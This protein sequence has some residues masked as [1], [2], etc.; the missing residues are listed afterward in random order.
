MICKRHTP[1]FYKG[2]AA[3]RE[4]R[5]TSRELVEQTLQ[6]IAMYEPEL[7]ATMAASR[8]T[9]ADDADHRWRSGL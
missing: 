9:P 1:V 8:K 5:V 2:I 4:G 7:G 3:M 6:R